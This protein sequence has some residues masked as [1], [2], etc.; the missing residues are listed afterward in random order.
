M[1]LRACYEQLGGDVAQ[2]ER[3]LSGE[4]LIGRFLAKFLD[5]SSFSDLC[6][7]MEEGSRDR[8]FHAAHAL[9]GVSGNLSLDRLY[10]S[11]SQLAELLRPAADGIPADAGPL[12]EVVERDHRLAVE[13]IR[14][15]L[16]SRCESENE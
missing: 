11:S 1:T 5:D 16:E 10:A 6:A 7:A 2:V 4:R 15:Y 3:R 14:A 13:A 12:L 8:A 9:K